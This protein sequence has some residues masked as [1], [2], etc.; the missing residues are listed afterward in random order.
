MANP[1]TTGPSG[2]GTEVLR[3]VYMYAQSNGSKTVLT[4]AADHVATILSLVINNQVNTTYP[5][6]IHVMPD[7]GTDQVILVDGNPLLVAKSTY[8]WN[9]KIVLTE[10]DV[11]RVYSSCTDFDIYCSYIDQEFA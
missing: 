10:T 11:L 3:R 2:E 5:M 6:N 7:G 8:I 4:V 1:S 9:D